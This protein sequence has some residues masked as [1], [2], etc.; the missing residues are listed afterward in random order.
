MKAG[1]LASWVPSAA[2]ARN[3]GAHLRWVMR[4]TR[5]DAADRS[6][7]SFRY[8]HPIVGDFVYHP[9]DYLSRRL[10]LYNDFERE[11]LRFAMYCA[12]GG[13]T[14]I[15]VGAN[16][17][18]FTV[19]CAR[20]AGP[21]GRVIALEP[22]PATYDKLTETCAVLRLLNV[23]LIQAAAGRTNGTAELITPRTSRDVHQHLADAREHDAA[24]RTQ[25]QLRR[26]DDLCGSD[27][28]RVALVKLD[29]EG[30]ECAALE[31]AERILSAGRPGLIV[32][33]YRRGLV[34]AGSSPEALWTLL[35]R[36]HACTAVIHEDG[37]RRSSVPSSVMADEVFN[38]LWEPR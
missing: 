30:H 4:R 12:R 1:Q 26:L 21:T 15:D 8:R 32:E 11:E 22:G 25:I 29:V 10:F 17:G 28:E 31:G 19:A 27:A 18:V 36:T 6:G 14:M 20:A 13:G 33:F 5:A 35:S 16:I 2:R 3:A 38:T 23:T 24:G 37:S 7:R 34:A 9:L